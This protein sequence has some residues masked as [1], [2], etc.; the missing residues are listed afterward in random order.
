[1]CAR[2]AS[3]RQQ[4]ATRPSLSRRN[5]PCRP[6]AVC[7]KERFR[8]VFLPFARRPALAISTARSCSFC[9]FYIFSLSLSAE[10]RALGLIVVGDGGGLTSHHHLQSSAP[11]KQQSAIDANKS[12][13]ACI[14]WPFSSP[15][16]KTLACKQA[17]AARF[18]LLSSCCCCCC[19]L[20]VV[21]ALVGCLTGWKAARR[22]HDKGSQ[23][24]TSA[25]RLS[26]VAIAHIHNLHI[27][28]EQAS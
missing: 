20:A 24:T 17:R 22:L 13:P 26:L 19:C 7:Q 10:S 5:R 4:R 18:L 27:E 12:R 3:A 15:Q 8:P 6:P 2:L 25:T 14:I 23:R 28:N 21:V 16:S 9:T 1:M 11:L